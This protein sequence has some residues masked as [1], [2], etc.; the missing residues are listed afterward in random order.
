MKN[1]ERRSVYTLDSTINQN[2]L[3]SLMRVHVTGGHISEAK[4]GHCV[5]KE[6]VEKCSFGGERG[7]YTCDDIETRFTVIRYSIL[8]AISMEG[9]VHCKIV[10]GSYNSELFSTFISEL[11]DHM[12]PFPMPQSVIV[13]DNCSIH[14]A[15]EIAEM[16]RGRCGI[17]V[18]HLT[19]MLIV[20]PGACEYCFFLHIRQI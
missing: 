11:L 15:P 16:I 10:E 17:S 4:H 14:K 8:P 1:F 19:Q 2:S 12:H 20:F 5:D 3:Y 18:L 7:K 9:I 13:M 6:P